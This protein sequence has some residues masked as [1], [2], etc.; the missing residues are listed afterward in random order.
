MLLLPLT[1]PRQAV[2][3]AALNDAPL[4]QSRVVLESIA[5]SFLAA[6]A[7]ESIGRKKQR[8][9]N[10]GVN[11][12]EKNAHGI[13]TLRDCRSLWRIVCQLASP[14]LSCV[15]KCAQVKLVFELR[16]EPQPAPGN[17]F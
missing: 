12:H 13:F 11:S 17:F 4:L 3:A 16:L 1:S 5:A 14:A 2:P 8:Q 9:A 6:N 15:K 10:G 7:F